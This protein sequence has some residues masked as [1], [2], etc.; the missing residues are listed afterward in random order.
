M[1]NFVTLSFYLLIL[2]GA[3]FFAPYAYAE[4]CKVNSDC[5]GT[6]KLCYYGEC[7][8]PKGA[9]D[10]AQELNTLKGWE[11]Y[12]ELYKA[13][14]CDD[15]EKQVKMIKGDK[16][17]CGK[18]RKTGSEK[19]WTTYLE[20]YPK[21]KCSKEAKKELKKIRDLKV[22]QKVRDIGD[23]ESWQKYLAK[24]PEGECAKEAEERIQAGICSPGQVN[25]KGHCCRE[26]QDWSVSGN[27][28]IDIG[29]RKVTKTITIG[30]ASWSLIETGSFKMGSPDDEVGHEPDESP[31]HDVTIRQSFLLKTTEVTQGEWR[32]LMGKDKNPSRFSNCGDDCPVEMVNWWETLAYS[33][34]LSY[35]QGFEECYKLSGC[36]DKKAGDDLECESVKFVGLG[37]K[38]YRLPTEAE[39]EYA[40]RSGSRGMYYGDNLADIAWFY[41]NSGHQT[42]SVGQKSPN[43]WGLYDMLG[44]V[45]EWTWDWYSK[46]HYASNHKTNILGAETGRDRVFRGGSWHSTTSNCRLAIRYYG[47]PDSSFGYVGF[48][49]ARS[50]D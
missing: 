16:K 27:Q 36:N 40:A 13:R 31:V 30:G 1:N 29:P 47:S 14:A 8:W 41:E 33:N 9:C 15:A 21:G 26:D 35:S 18:A 20:K 25:V 39:W 46:E 3:V 24:Y 38:G 48:R 7:L 45:Y 43:E 11:T 37:C 28:C 4:N 12:L 44:N 32:S 17:E 6:T 10:K 42:H 22:C 23:V 5:V 19:N 49:L 34:A 50:L 2:S